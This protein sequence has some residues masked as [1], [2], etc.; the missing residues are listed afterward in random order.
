VPVL[1][2]A[3]LIFFL[4][5]R[6]AP[7][8]GGAGPLGG[9][10]ENFG[11]ALEYGVFA[12]CLALLAPRRRDERGEWVDLHVR[13]SAAILLFVSLY[14]ASD[15]WHQSFVPDRDASAFDV[16]T[17]VVGACSTIACIAAIGRRAGAGWALGLRFAVGILACLASAALATYGFP[18][19]WR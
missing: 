12:V 10:F 6:P 11:H 9:V 8:F 13:A 15:E 18:W 19:T 2:W 14:A 3:S 5:S 7:S 17:D 16:L 4:S 1:A